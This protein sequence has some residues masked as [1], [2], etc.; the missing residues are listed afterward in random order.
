MFVY[1]TEEVYEKIPF[2]MSDLGDY[3]YANG[4]KVPL[5][6]EGNNILVP[7]EEGL[8]LVTIEE[9]CVVEVDGEVALLAEKNPVWKI[10]IGK[11]VVKVVSHAVREAIKDNI[12]DTTIKRVI[13]DGKRIIQPSYYDPK[14]GWVP[15]RRVAWYRGVAVILEKNTNEVVTVFKLCKRSLDKRLLK[16][17]LGERGGWIERHWTL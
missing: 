8:V 17:K 3:A 6:T 7:T 10:A 9:F 15:E 16:G 13:K 5:K 4:Q 1:E 2:S 14:R 11:V 12:R